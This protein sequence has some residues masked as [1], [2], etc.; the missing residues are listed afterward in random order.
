MNDDPGCHSAT[1]QVHCPEKPSAGNRYYRKNSTNQCGY[2][3]LET[4][5]SLTIL[6]IVVVPLLSR[7]YQNTSLADA[8]YELVG[9]RLIEQEAALV[10]AMP[11]EFSPL[12]KRY[13]DK[14]EWTIRADVAA[15]GPLRYTLAAELHGTV[16]ARAVFYGRAPDAAK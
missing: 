10:C 13:V 12:K 15:N 2:T 7:L 14:Q 8:R 11:N 6:M 4:V 1:D 16:R 3:L 5:I 9:I